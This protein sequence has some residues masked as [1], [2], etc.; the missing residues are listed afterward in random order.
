MISER[1]N[2]LYDALNKE[3]LYSSGDFVG[4]LHSDDIYA[5]PNV[6]TDIVTCLVNSGRDSWYA[7]L[8][9]VD[10]ENTDKV[11]RNWVSGEINAKSFLNGEGVSPR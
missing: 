6:I 1:D 10:Q 7:D 5:Y 8:Q 11:F 9:Y 2:G 3:I 4:F